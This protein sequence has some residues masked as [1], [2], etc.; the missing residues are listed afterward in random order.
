MSMTMRVFSLL[1][2]ALPRIALT[3]DPYGP[4]TFASA[5]QAAESLIRAVE[6]DD[7]AALHSI[8]GPQAK[9]LI[10]TGDAVADKKH[11]ENFSHDLQAGWKLAPD[12]VRADRFIVV[13]GTK[14]WPFPISIVKS[15]ALWHYDTAEGRKEILARLIGGNEITAIEICRAYV[16]AQR[17]YAAVRRDGT[18]PRQ[19]AQHIV[20]SPGK[21]DGLYWPAASGEAASPASEVFARMSAE[22][23][24]EERGKP[25]IFHGY[26]FRVLKAQ[27]THAQGGAR[28]Y[29]AKGYMI[30]GFGLVAFPIS[31]G[32]TGITTFI[33]NQDGVVYEKD[34]G[35][36]T[37]AIATKMKVYDPDNSWHTAP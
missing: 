17:E 2:L 18:E 11:R 3:S 21:K 25:K 5:Q 16:D 6:S 34:L 23:Y 10:D 12:P 28:D 32:V 31:Y 27:G 37:V 9:D 20:S 33:V 24:T 13:V 26:R 8:L 15:Q 14:E 19:Y 7:V 35:K 29:V 1:L 36:K 4:Q 22:G 30:G